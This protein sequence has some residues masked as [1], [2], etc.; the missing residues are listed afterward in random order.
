MHLIRVEYLQIM[1]RGFLKHFADPYNWVDVTHL[2]MNTIFLVFH[3]IEN[4]KFNM[5]RQRTWSGISVC[6][7]WLKLF[8]W[9]RLFDGTAFFMR[10]LT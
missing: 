3:R 2:T 7:L 4:S 8:D 9:M 5:D 10:L 1:K 6:V